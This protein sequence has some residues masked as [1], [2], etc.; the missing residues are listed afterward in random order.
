[1]FFIQ[2]NIYL[3]KIEQL[4]GYA[5]FYTDGAKLTEALHKLRQCKIPLHDKNN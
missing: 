3:Y 1:M 4:F 2:K 5:N